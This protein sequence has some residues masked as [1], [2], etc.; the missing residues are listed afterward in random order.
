MVCRGQNR[1][2]DKKPPEK[3][4][5]LKLLPCSSRHAHRKEHKRTEQ[6]LI[7]IHQHWVDW[8]AQFLGLE[9]SGSAY[10]T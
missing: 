9:G 3:P 2:I 1:G 6:Q 8:P 4:S 5:I 10:H 7:G